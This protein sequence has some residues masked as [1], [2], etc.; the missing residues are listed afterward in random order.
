MRQCLSSEMPTVSETET[1]PSQVVAMQYAK[2]DWERYALSA[3]KK[4]IGT[5][6]RLARGRGRR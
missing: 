2:C 6:L 1:T 5:A 4:Y 3:L